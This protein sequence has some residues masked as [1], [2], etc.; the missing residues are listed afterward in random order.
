LLVW[1]FSFSIFRYNQHNPSTSEPKCRTEGEA[2]ALALG[3]KIVQAMQISS[4][5]FFS[6]SQ[7]LVQFL[8]KD[9]QDHLSHWRMKPYTQMYANIARIYGGPSIQD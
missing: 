7:Q 5:T 2:A 9:N 1:V 6:D 8:H 4:C 3:A